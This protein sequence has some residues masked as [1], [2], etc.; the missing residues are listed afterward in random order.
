MLCYIYWFTYAEPTL[1]FRDEAQ[2]VI[3]L[4]RAF[5]SMFVKEIGV[6]LTFSFSSCTFFRWLWYQDDIGFIKFSSAP[7]LSI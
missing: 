1:P 5:V 6:Y 3:I 4:L 2:F 7:L